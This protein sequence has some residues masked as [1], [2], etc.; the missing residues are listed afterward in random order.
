MTEELKEAEKSSTP[1]ELKSRHSSEKTE[2]Q[3]QKVH[4]LNYNVNYKFISAKREYAR[5]LFEFIVKYKF[6]KLNLNS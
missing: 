6:F 3:E 4:K 2:F 5:K 1:D